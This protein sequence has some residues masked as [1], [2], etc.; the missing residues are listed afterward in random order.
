MDKLKT[1]DMRISKLI[2]SLTELTNIAL[3]DDPVA[4]Q[5]VFYNMK[6]II[7]EECHYFSYNVNLEIIEKNDEINGRYNLEDSTI[8]IVIE[9]K[10]NMAIVNTMAHELRHA[11]QHYNGWLHL[12]FTQ[13][14]NHSKVVENYMYSLEDFPTEEEHVRQVLYRTSW[15]EIDARRYAR[16]F[17]G[18][19][20]GDFKETENFDINEDNIGKELISQL[21]RMGEL[22]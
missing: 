16:W 6:Y 11:F 20:I 3:K 17:T 14:D 2:S 10:S 1:T 9:D 13:K 4:C 19:G 12:S 15:H 21:L 18:G 8:Q 5:L 7:L 22:E